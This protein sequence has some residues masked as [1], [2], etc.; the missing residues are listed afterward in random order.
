VL[1][2]PRPVGGFTNRMIGF[3][4]ATDP[5]LAPRKGPRL[6]AT[7]ARSAGV[8]A[9]KSS[10]TALGIFLEALVVPSAPLGL[11]VPEGLADNDTGSAWDEVAR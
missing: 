7:R 10:S 6:T 4:R 3:L 2:T 11:V 8:N 1:A 9:G 5:A